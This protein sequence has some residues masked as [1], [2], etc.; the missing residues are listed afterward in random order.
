ME[1]ITTAIFDIGNTLVRVDWERISREAAKTGFTVAAETLRRAAHAG[2]IYIDNK[3]MSPE[4]GS[5][6]TRWDTYFQQIFLE[7]GYP[8]EKLQDFVNEIQRI[9]HIGF[10]LWSSI[11]PD[12]VPLLEDL[13][14]KGYRLGIISNAD[15]RIEGLVNE[16]GIASYFDAVIDS[17]VVGVEKP[18]KQIFE[19]AMQ[20]LNCSPPEAMYTGDIYSVDVLG[21]RSAGLTAA[22]VDPFGQYGDVD[23]IVVNRLLEL[24]DILQGPEK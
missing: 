3:I 6:K 5:D 16:L 11:D 14:S 15:G 17:H 10:G 19:I 13:S 7:I 24:Q 1:N 2:V 23:C 4:K 21:A 22:L 9:D 8:E 12:T 20:E 18:N